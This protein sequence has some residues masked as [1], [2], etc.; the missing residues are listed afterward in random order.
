MILADES[1]EAIT[2]CIWGEFAHKF[3]LGSD[4]HPVVAVKRA[5]VSDF[6]G[7]SLNSNDDS[8]IV[9]NPPHRRTKQLADWYKFLPDT[10]VI[11]CLNRQTNGESPLK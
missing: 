10:S 2:L 3:D 8:H 4:E 9:V 11:Q 7:K 1:G 5:T 6:N